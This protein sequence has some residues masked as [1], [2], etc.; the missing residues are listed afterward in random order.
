[1]ERTAAPSTPPKLVVVIPTYN[2]RENIAP[3][4][5]H[6]ESLRASLA[7]FDIHV[8]FVDDSSPDGTANEIEGLRDGTLK[9][10]LL[11]RD[12]KLGI[13][14][15]Y[16]DG[17]RLALDRLS[18]SI[19]VEMDAD[20]QHPPEMIA[21]LASAVRE[22]ADVAIASRY[23]EGGGRR[24]WGWRRRAVSKGANFLARVVLGL[25][26][27]DCTSGFRAY[28]EAAVSILLTEHIPTSGF[29]FQVAALFVLVKRGLKV[30]EVPFTFVGRRRGKSK[31]SLVEMLRFFFTLPWLRLTY[32]RVSNS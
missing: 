8:L 18:P 28:S 1:M 10:L 19:Y 12:A 22:G 23:V 13:G 15:A 7:E 32:R 20:L 9:V 11:R 30:A 21:K 29:V 24:R 26:A 5:Q 27:K 4:F 6:F 3:L 17:F 14:S 16:L 31:L 25:S 2:E